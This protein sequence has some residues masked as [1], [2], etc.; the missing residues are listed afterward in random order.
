LVKIFALPGFEDTQ[1]GFKMFR[2]ETAD[3]I[4]RSQVFDGMSFD[5]EALYIARRRGCKIV[6]VP[7]DWYYRSESRVQPLLDPLRMLRDVLVIRRNWQRGLYS[8]R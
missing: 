1:C 7:I 6:E 2:G 5:V 4:F 3:D 8:K